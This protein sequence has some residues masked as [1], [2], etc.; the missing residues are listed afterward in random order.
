MD[1][2]RQRTAV[3]VIVPDTSDCVVEARRNVVVPA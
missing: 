2:R 3:G 1:A